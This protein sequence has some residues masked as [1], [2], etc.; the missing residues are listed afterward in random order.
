MDT[1]Q[2]FIRLKLDT[3]N[4][5]ELGDFVGA[6][7]AL[8]SEYERYVRTARPDADPAATLFVREVRTGCVEA[9]LIPWLAATAPLLI[10]NANTLADFVKNYGAW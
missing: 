3:D 10:A 4:P 2:P 7:T 6:F 8:A 1:A 5:I 9:D